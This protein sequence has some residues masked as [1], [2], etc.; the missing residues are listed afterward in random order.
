MINLSCSQ[1]QSVLNHLDV[2]ITEGTVLTKHVLASCF[3]SS[4]QAVLIELNVACTQR[5]LTIASAPVQK[6][7]PCKSLQSWDS[8]T[9]NIL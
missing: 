6:K 9:K 2:V 7:I 3:V 1:L 8:Q 5:W 4:I